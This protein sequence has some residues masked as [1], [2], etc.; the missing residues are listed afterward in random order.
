MGPRSPGLAALA[1]ALVMLRA[2]LEY[3]ARAVDDAE[4]DYA[5]AGDGERDAA[6]Q[7][8]DAAHVKLAHLEAALKPWPHAHH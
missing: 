3:A 6:C 7:A 2:E 4:R 1:R 5:A 8:L